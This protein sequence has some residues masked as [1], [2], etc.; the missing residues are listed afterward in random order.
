M[1]FP[2]PTKEPKGLGPY[3]DLRGIICRGKQGNATYQISKLWELKLNKKRQICFP[4]QTISSKWP[5]D[6]K[7]LAQGA[8]LLPIVVSKGMLHAKNLRSGHCTYTQNKSQKWFSYVSPYKSSDPWGGTNIEPRGM[9]HMSFVKLIKAFLH[10]KYI[11]S[12]YYSFRQRNINA[13]FKYVFMNQIIP[14]YMVSRSK[15]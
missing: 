12:R 2:I 14:V 8:V 5:I 4:V 3:I 10:V 11:S 7:I 13:I 15:V 9:I 6:G 1:F